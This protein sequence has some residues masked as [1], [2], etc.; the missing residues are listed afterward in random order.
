[1]GSATVQATGRAVST[2][3]FFLAQKHTR[4]VWQARE[5]QVKPPKGLSE[6]RDTKLLRCTCYEVPIELAQWV[7]QWRRIWVPPLRSPDQPGRPLSW[8]LAPGGVQKY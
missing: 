1:M 8:A 6:L 7:P 4:Y 3:F 5:L 2:Q